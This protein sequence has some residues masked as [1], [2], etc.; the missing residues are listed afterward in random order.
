MKVRI[1][2]K[3]RF[4]N[5]KK[6]N[7][8]FVQDQELVQDLVQGHQENEDLDLGLVLVSGNTEN[9]RARDQEKGRESHLGHTPVKE[10]LGKGKKN[11]RK[12]DCLLYGQRH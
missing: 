6:R 3:K 9:V 7:Q 2:L 11:V 5:K 4:L 8:L 12:R 10:G 1:L